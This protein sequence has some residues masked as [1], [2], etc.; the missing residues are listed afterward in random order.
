MTRKLE[1]LFQLPTISVLE[2]NETQESSTNIK[3]EI[4][5][6]KQLLAN[7]DIAIDKID[8]ALP[9]VHDLDTT[10]KDLDDLADLAKN[11]FTDLI[12]LSMNCEP[13][14]SGPILQSASTLLGHA[15][16]AK[17]AKMDKKLKMVELQIKKARIDQDAGKDPAAHAVDG[18]GMILDRNTLLREILNNTIK[19]DK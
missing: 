13:R 15:I 18:K 2:Q 11:T 19:L 14:F 1:E 3:S 10:D 12:D 6:N 16:T 4:E 9:L 17:V 8:A 7:A 5:E